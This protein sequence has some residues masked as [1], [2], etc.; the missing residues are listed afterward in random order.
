MD[1][2]DLHSHAWL[3][4]ASGLRIVVVRDWTATISQSRCLQHVIAPMSFEYSRSRC[5]NDVFLRCTCT[6]GSLAHCCIAAEQAAGSERGKVAASLLYHL[7]SPRRCFEV[8]LLE[9]YRHLAEKPA[10]HGKRADEVSTQTR[11]YPVAEA[12]DMPLCIEEVN[13][14]ELSN[15]SRQA[16]TQMQHKQAHT[17][18]CVLH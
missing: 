18:R 10:N 4:T 15:R 6:L 8:C 2:S 11:R 3:T 7:S 5:Q 1:G 14:D 16:R 12:D 17:G 9:L 13:V